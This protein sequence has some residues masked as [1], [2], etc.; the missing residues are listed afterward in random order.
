MPSGLYQ[1]H[2]PRPDPKRGAPREFP[3]EE[4]RWNRHSI[5]AGLIGTILFHLLF[6]FSIPNSYLDL[7]L[8]EPADEVQEFDIQLVEPEEEEEEPEQQQFVETN[9]AAPENAPDETDNFSARDQQAANETEPEELSEDRTPAREGEDDVPFDKMLSGELTEPQVSPP[10]APEQ[11]AVQE[12]TQ[13][14][15]PQRQDPLP[16]FEEGRGESEE[17]TGSSIAEPTDNPQPDAEKVEGEDTPSEDTELPV[18]VSPLTGSQPSPAPRPRLPRA[19][20]GPVRRQEAGVSQTGAIAVDAKFSE[21]GQYLERMIEAVSQRWTALCSSRAYRESSTHVVIEFKV[22]REGLIKDI[23]TIENTSE[24]L[25]V[26]LAQSAIEQ[27]QPYGPWPQ[28]MIDVLG[29]NQTVTFSF[30]YW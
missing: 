10:P 4:E 26:L 1:P 25:G 11:P 3:I 21:Y 18:F 28:E 27:G 19:L 24:A 23:A 7:G 9:Q 13:P 20:P 30:H 22:T 6:F 8:K 16:G 5:L 2:T 14:S 17:G 29:E 12:Q 15:A